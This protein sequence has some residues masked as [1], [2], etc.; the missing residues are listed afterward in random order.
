[1]L[2]ASGAFINSLLEALVTFIEIKCLKGDE[3]HKMHVKIIIADAVLTVAMILTASAEATMEYGWSYLDGF[4]AWWVTSTT[5]GFG[6]FVPHTKGQSGAY[7]FLTLVLTIIILSTVASMINAITEL[8]DER[9]KKQLSKRPCPT[10][11]PCFNNKTSQT[12]IQATHG[13]DG[14]G[15]NDVQSMDEN[16][17]DRKGIQNA[18]YGME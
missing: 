3:V 13:N 2:S 5:V 17:N 6:D 1:M 10:L 7:I 9:A 14:S 15:G 16:R 8:I 4:Y 12:N 18:A 11:C